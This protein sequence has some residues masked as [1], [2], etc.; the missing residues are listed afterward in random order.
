MLRSLRTQVTLTIAVVVLATIALISVLANILIGHEFEKNAGELRVARS[1][2]IVD[3]LIRQYDMS[4]GRWNLDYLHGMGMYALYEG[5]IIRVYDKN[6]AVIWD[7]ENHDMSLC[8][9]IMAD[10]SA[11]MEEKRPY[12]NGGFTTNE[13]Q[14]RQADSSIGRVD[15]TSYGPYFLTDND[16][17][18]LE[19]LNLILSVNGLLSFF[20]SL[21]AGGVLARRISGPIAKTANVA[22]QIAGGDF[23]IR[24]EGRPKSKEVEE[25]V[26]AVN[27]MAESLEQQE[28]LRR[29]LT[30]NMAHELRTPLSAVSA[31]LEL[32]IE[33]VWEA[34]PQR[35]QSCA[36]EINRLAGLVSE[37]EKLAQIE[38]DILK[39]N[40]VA[41]DLLELAK[42]VVDTFAGEAKMK[43][44]EI[45]LNGEPA[46][47]LADRER[48]HQVIANLLSNAIKYT[49]LNGRIAVGVRNSSNEGIIIIQDDGRGIEK[50]AWPFIFERFYRTDKSRNRKTGGAGIGLTI[51]KSIVTAHGGK[52]EVTSEI[53]KGS[54]FSVFLPKKANI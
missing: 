32:M 40:P 12:L 54:K 5:Y 46:I 3:N 14:L 51:V 19:D 29:E 33:G 48:I 18:F 36:E 26:S 25:L 53:D 49:A 44:I 34:T 22:S 52:I 23:G 47:I 28:N 2:D 30:G 50:N 42:A 4:A 9:Q 21:I 8:E 43:N 10:I 39:L 16:L 17:R 24:F 6:N 31:H 11:R 20:L 15:I 27:Y 7:A 38:N 41:V 37:L 45:R 35:L 13:Y 1:R